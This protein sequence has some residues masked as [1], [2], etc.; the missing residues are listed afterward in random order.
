MDN[1]STVLAWIQG[2]SSKWKTFMGNRVATI[3]ELSLNSLLQVT[4]Y[5]KRFAYNCRQPLA[6]RQFTALTMQDL[7]QAL[8]CCVKGAQ[9]SS[10]EQELKELLNH[11]EVSAK[12]SLRT[13]HPF[14][15][16]KGVLRV[17]GR[18]QQSNLPYHVIHQVILPP[19]HHFTKLIVSSENI[20][21]HHAGPGADSITSGEILDP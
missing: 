21:L 19:R 6:N 15:D 7:D 12:S 3:Q 8:T 5:C 18:L 14:I 13:L 20:R 1:T 9:R 10:Y 4:A 11:Q 17:G 2:P 16:D